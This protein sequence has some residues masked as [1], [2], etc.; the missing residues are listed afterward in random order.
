MRRISKGACDYCGLDVEVIEVGHR[1]ICDECLLLA[2]K[3]AEEAGMFH[4]E[5]D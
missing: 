5:E 3:M 2:A 4:V 1:R